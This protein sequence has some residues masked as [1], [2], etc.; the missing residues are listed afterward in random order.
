MPLQR[1]CAACKR[2]FVNRLILHSAG[3]RYRDIAT[4][5]LDKIRK[6]SSLSSNACSPTAATTHTLWF[7]GNRRTAKDYEAIASAFVT[8]ATIQV[9]LRRCRSAHRLSS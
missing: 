6:R 5:L 3:V 8:L 9:A 2:T 4:L 7:G 1:H